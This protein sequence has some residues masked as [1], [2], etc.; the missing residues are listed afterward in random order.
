MKTLK[1][2][3]QLQAAIQ[4]CKENNP[5]L[6]YEMIGYRFGMNAARVSK[7]LK[8]GIPYPAAYRQLSKR[9]NI[10]IEE[11]SEKRE[12]G[13]RW[14]SKCAGWF[15]D[16]QFYESGNLTRKHSAHLCVRGKRKGK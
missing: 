3:L 7:M 16:S 12:A 2:A 8:G 11:V 10:A 15:E 5:E 9:L 6:T 1:R 13:L 14:C 4:K